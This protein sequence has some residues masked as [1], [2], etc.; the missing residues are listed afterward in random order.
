MV[1]KEKSYL[2]IE[3]S[4]FSNQKESIFDSW[5]TSDRF[6]R[7][8][9]KKIRTLTSEQKII[10]G[11][12]V[13]AANHARKLDNCGDK[14]IENRYTTE[15]TPG[16]TNGQ[17]PSASIPITSSLGGATGDEQKNGTPPK[18]G[19]SKTLPNEQR[20]KKIY[21]LSLDVS[22]EW[23]DIMAIIRT[24]FPDDYQIDIPA[25][26]DAAKRYAKKTN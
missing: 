22:N 15:A 14:N 3:G 11:K 26:Q 1:R 20:D 9:R 17:T 23:N 5:Q 4:Q 12:C 10:L 2:H 6:K 19:Q 25:L 18:G 8:V 16:T 24:K 21:E 7:F 13:D